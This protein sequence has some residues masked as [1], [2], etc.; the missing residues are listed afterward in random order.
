[1]AIKKYEIDGKSYWDV[2]VNVRSKEIPSVREQK[3]VYRLES[4]K[5]AKSEEKRLYRELTEKMTIRASL[6]FTWEV[7]IGKWELAMRS[8]QAYYK[9]QPV[10]ILDHVSCLTRWTEAWHKKP[11]ASLNRADARDV[12]NALEQ[13][14]KSNGFQKHVKNTINVVY[15]WGIEERLIKNVTVTPVQGMSITREK[16]EKVPDIFTLDEIRKFL[17]F[18]KQL[19]HPWYPIWAM[20]LLT[21][22]RNGELVA[23]T[24]ADVDLENRKITV[25]K[26]YNTRLRSV[27]CTK[28][29]YWRTVPISDDLLG[30]LKELKATSQNRE[31]V[32]PKINQWGKG[33]QA[34]VLKKFCIG[35]GLKPIKF[36][37]LRACFATQLLAHDVAPAQVMKICGWKDL[38]TMQYYIRLAGIDERGATQVLRILPSDADVMGEV[39]SIYAGKPQNS[40]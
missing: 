2:Y 29:G 15:R 25:S 5:V 26:S 36:H 20:A 40:G 17:K 3:H 35:V 39:V 9:Y 19:E 12:F 27:K 16:A 14:G 6:G 24:W 28:A 22:M 1:M 38:K 33:N 32:L 7:V 23:L 8:E 10:T 11:A 13:A 30:I 31:D 34:T 21:G 18:A 37:A 4:E